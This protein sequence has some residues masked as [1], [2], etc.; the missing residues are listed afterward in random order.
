MLGRKFNVRKEERLTP[1]PVKEAADA[2]DDGAGHIMKQTQITNWVPWDIKLFKAARQQMSIWI[3][4]NLRLTIARDH[5]MWKSRGLLCNFS[6]VHGISHSLAST[7]PVTWSTI[8]REEVRG[9]L[10]A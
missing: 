9:P 6:H 3:P 4:M 5:P 1:A 7:K 2:A 8:T 10:A